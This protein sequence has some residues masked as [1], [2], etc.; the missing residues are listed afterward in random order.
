MGVTPTTVL[1][2]KRW[3]P[4]VGALGVLDWWSWRAVKSRLHRYGIDFAV[5]RNAGRAVLSNHALYGP[6]IGRDIPH[7]LP[8]TYPPLAALL[9]VPLAFVG[10]QSG[11]LIWD[12][13]QILV[14]IAVVRLVTKPFAG[15]FSNPIVPLALGTAVALALT[16]VQDELGFG[17]VGIVLMGLCVFDC[18]IERPPWPRGALIGVAAAIKLVPA[19]FIPYLWLSGR[20]RAAGVATA[21]FAALSLAGALVLPRDSTTFWTSQLFDNH[22][23]GD[24]AYFSNQ[25]LNG[26]MLRALGSH[27]GGLLTSTLWIAVA[28]VVGGYG[29][30]RA[31]RAARRGDQLLGLAL[32][33]LVG[34]LVSPVSW[35][36]HLV[37]IVPIIAVVLGDATDR[38][39]VAVALAV[40]AFFALRLPYVG[41]YMP[42]QWHVTWLAGPL[43]D[44][45][46]LACLGLLLGL[47]MLLRGGGPVPGPGGGA[48]VPT[49]R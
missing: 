45:F 32:A 27:G 17:Q 34:V 28:V 39:R 38:R 47:P 33:A 29:L 21:V 48:A 18:L 35:I 22:R 30:S 46:G 12:L 40:A 2:T 43:K 44:S 37:W 25:S 19:I 8:F 26:I 23:V 16:P 10:R 49:T 41:H 7:R 36:H 1:P 5:Y 4:V 9:A 42:A 11:L 6:W 31:A 13:A 15:R 14:L 20:R 24:N 3:L